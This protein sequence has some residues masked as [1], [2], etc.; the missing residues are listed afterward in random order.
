MN[1]VRAREALLIKNRDAIP[2]AD[3]NIQNIN[4][5]ITALTN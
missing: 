2:G 5:A 1:A 4:N 3:A